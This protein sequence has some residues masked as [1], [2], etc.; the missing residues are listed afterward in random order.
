M[1]YNGCSVMH[2]TRSK[3]DFPNFF[4]KFHNAKS[5]NEFEITQSWC[6][7][8]FLFVPEIASR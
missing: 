2:G 6:V 1:T 7:F 3:L 5:K 4:E 8:R